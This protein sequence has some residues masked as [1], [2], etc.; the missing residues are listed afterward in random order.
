M[1]QFKGEII[2]SEVMK[3]EPNHLQAI[4]ELKNL[5]LFS[6]E[7]VEEYLQTVSHLYQNI[8]IANV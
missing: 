3:K 4:E 6:E 7:S 8:H 5:L 1:N 2:M